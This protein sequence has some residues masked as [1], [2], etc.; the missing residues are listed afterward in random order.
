MKAI[1]EL[2]LDGRVLHITLNAPKANVL[3]SE[4][5]SGIAQALEQ[6]GPKPDLSAIV[7]EGAG[8]HFSFG[9]SVEEH[10]KDRVAGM[11]TGFHDLFRRMAG[12]CVPTAAVVRG[13]CLGGGLE[14]ASWCTWIFATPDAAFAQPEVRLGV[15]PPMASLLLPWRVGGAAA[16][17]LCVSGRTVSAAEAHRM[18]LITAIADDPAA[19]W[20]TFYTEHLAPKSAAA[21]RFAERAARLGLM[22]R[23]A[24]DLP[25]LERLYLDHLI[26]THDANEGL[27]AFLEKR[28]AVW[29][30]S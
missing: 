8:P 1:V 28:T 24:E 15:F 7:F 26:A 23:L 4:M 2:R 10:R 13:Q 18:G 19:A 14:L 16:T 27:A 12:L 20:E 11:L 22:Q 25:A 30:H 21:L 3:D 5:M 6:Y 17:D 9:A 29:R